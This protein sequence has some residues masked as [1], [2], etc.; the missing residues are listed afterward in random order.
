M[1]TENTK[2]G[3]TNIKE[4]VDSPASVLN[5]VEEQMHCQIEEINNKIEKLRM[6]IKEID[7]RMDEFYSALFQLQDYIK[8][9]ERVSFER[10]AEIQRL[11][12]ELEQIRMKTKDYDTT[13]SS[14]NDADIIKPPPKN[15]DSGSG[16]IQV[17]NISILVNQDDNPDGD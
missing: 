6:D 5:I 17:G 2:E 9:S 10:N 8:K 14:K 3:L 1:L 12:F 16:E 11:A 7:E 4:D 13:N 15:I